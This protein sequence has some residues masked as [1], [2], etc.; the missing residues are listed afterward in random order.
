MSIRI[1]T[2]SSTFYKMK[3]LVRNM[4]K[5]LDKKVKLTLI[6]EDV[7]VDKNVIECVTDPLMH[8]VH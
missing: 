8:M 3:R 7:E 4:S 1:V 5:K 2:M 6:G